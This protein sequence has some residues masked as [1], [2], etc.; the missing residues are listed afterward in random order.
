VPKN[1]TPKRTKAIDVEVHDNEEDSSISSD[2]DSD[3]DAIDLSVPT[4]VK[5]EDLL[6]VDFEFYDP[7]DGDFHSIKQLLNKRLPQLCK[8]FYLSD[9]TSAIVE[10]SEVGTLVRV[11]GTEH[12]FAFAT[13]LPVNKAHNKS[14]F[15]NS[16]KN[17][18]VKKCPVDKIK[19]FTAAIENLQ[20]GLLI[21]ERIFNIPDHLVSKIYE[22]LQQDIQWAITSAPDQTCR[23]TFDM[24]HFLLLAPYSTDN[25]KNSNNKSLRTFRRHEEGFIEKVADVKFDITLEAP[26]GSISSNTSDTSVP[27]LGPQRFCVMV[28]KGTKL[29]DAVDDFDNDLPPLPESSD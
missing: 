5:K 24:D 19:Q 28:V 25:A 27:S 10:Q 21:S 17:A 3:E 13:A 11:N 26:E 6:Q 8:G 20:L 15:W 22:N 16:M 2:I 9:L 23:K 14:D 1:D 12:V 4:K 29:R 7:K 18:L